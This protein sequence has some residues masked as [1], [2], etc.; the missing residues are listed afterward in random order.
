MF[1]VHHFGVSGYGKGS[2]EIAKKGWETRRRNKRINNVC[3]AI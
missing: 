1:G 3:A 2:S